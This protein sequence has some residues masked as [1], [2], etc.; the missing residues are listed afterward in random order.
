[1]ITTA[2]SACQT[3]QPNLALTTKKTETNIKRLKIYLSNETKDRPNT[4]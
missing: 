4:K 3:R 1:M 2:R